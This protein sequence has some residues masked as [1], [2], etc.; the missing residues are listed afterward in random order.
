[1]LM[2]MVT[3]LPGRRLPAATALLAAA[4][5]L[6]EA[7]AAVHAGADLVDL[8]DSGDFSEFSEFS[9]FSEGSGP[10]Q[11]SGLGEVGGFRDL[12]WTDRPTVAEFR[13]RHP[14]VLVCA[15]DEGADLV[16]HPAV[17]IATGA[18][19]IC[20]DPAAARATGLPAARVIVGV[21]PDGVA[22]AAAAG[23]VT[24]VDVDQAADLAKPNML[25]PAN[26]HQAAD[27]A[28]PN[29]PSPANPHQ[30]A[31]HR[32]DDPAELAGIVAIAALSSWLGAAIVRTRYP[33]QVR[34]ALDMAAT[35]QG[36]RPPARTVRGLA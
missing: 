4:A 13:A 2:P 14:G 11:G 8:V 31:V 5:S 30:A 32:H 7:A 36:I 28:K 17:A 26:P 24:M 3:P 16:R 18:L 33:L 15:T 23:W 35:I 34:R 12:G 9:G 20:A 29:M 1:M 22:A 6:S 27:P 21:M 10:G 25:S 19:L